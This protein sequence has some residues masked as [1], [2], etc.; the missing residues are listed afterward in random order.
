MPTKDQFINVLSLAREWIFSNPKET[1]DTDIT[2]LHDVERFI[3][4]MSDD[5]T[6][7]KS[8]F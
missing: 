3:N 5:E 6:N 7:T 1:D 2:D 4:Q 8:G